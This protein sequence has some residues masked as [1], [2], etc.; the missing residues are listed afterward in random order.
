M[1]GAIT[2]RVSKAV[3]QFDFQLVD[4][5]LPANSSVTSSTEVSS[6]VSDNFN[7]EL[8]GSSV[9]D[10]DS[11]VAS[12]NNSS[13]KGGG[14]GLFSS[15][16]DVL[17]EESYTPEH[18]EQERQAAR[19]TTEVVASANNKPKSTH[20]LKNASEVAIDVTENDAKGI[21][22]EKLTQMTVALQEKEME[23]QNVRRQLQ[24]QRTI[25]ADQSTE[26]AELIKNARKEAASQARE[27]TAKNAALTKELAVLQDEHT[28]RMEELQLEHAAAMRKVAT[29]MAASVKMSCERKADDASEASAVTHE[30][31]P[32]ESSSNTDSSDV[33]NTAQYGTGVSSDS[34]GTPATTSAESGL[35]AAEI[36]R[37]EALLSERNA[38]IAKAKR[39]ISQLRTELQ[40]KTDALIHIQTELRASEDARRG[41]EEGLSAKAAVVADRERALE[42]AG[43]QLAEAQAL[44]NTIASLEEQLAI[45]RTRATEADAAASA[46]S[47]SQMEVSQLREQLAAQTARLASFESEGQVLA[48]KQSE[49]EKLV[50]KTKAESKA[51][52]GELADLVK[53]K[54]ALEK[55]IEEQQALLTQRDTAANGATKSLHALQAASQASF[56]KISRLQQECDSRQE[57]LNTA[58][59]ALTKAAEDAAAQQLLLQSITQ[60]QQALKRQVDATQCA[61]LET[62][63]H[64]RDV[65]SREGLLRATNAQLQEGLAHHMAD[66][67]AR[68]ER[69]REELQ[70]M[71]KRWQEALSAR[72]ALVAE[73]NGASAPLLRQLTQLQETLRVRSEAWQAAESALSERALRAESAREVAEHK[74][75]VTTEA[76]QLAQ[77]QLVS[78]QEKLAA[79]QKATADANQSAER[80]RANEHTAQASAREA[81]AA[82]ALEVAQLR[83]LQQSVRDMEHDHEITLAKLA[84]VHEL[85]L[86]EA[87]STQRRLDTQIQELCTE[88]ELARRTQE[89]SGLPLGTPVPITRPAVTSEVGSGSPSA[90]IPA[91]LTAA[92]E[93]TLLPSGK[94]S[95]ASSTRTQQLLQQRTEQLNGAQARVSQLERA[96]QALLAEVTTL[97]ARNAKLEEEAA[98]MSSLT[99]A[100][101]KSRQETEVLLLLV[102]EKE[103]E[104]EAAASDLRDVRALYREQMETLLSADLK[105]SNA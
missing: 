100:L 40:E 45:E 54:A 21:E 97:S 8:K 96:R 44:H 68:E 66:A 2:T 79:A 87:H 38:T 85:A 88:L 18:A 86:A 58:R 65:E 24:E 26:S 33:V 1:W 47:F 73:M 77:A 10:I 56:E 105:A 74:F 60:E 50:R 91:R 20:S 6:G 98:N 103:E 61:A 17:S 16:A 78:I 94:E 80:A 22:R 13:S 42:V 25:N 5:Q 43:A 23:L 37:L 35:A 29:E 75:A 67:A 39:G 53:T 71:R 59:A 12:S 19:A 83:G 101:A 72:E 57:E 95:F 28:R 36:S 90:S 27:Y 15:I 69:L 48:K 52:D 11:N 4:G 14:W 9:S 32:S 84:A 34:K 31:A 62:D 82:L 55:V 93:P 76:A 63:A 89:Q 92:T 46:S 30:Q 99:E 104:L 51:R 102:G 49:M 70:D 81:Q 3:D 64:R 7:P 41:L